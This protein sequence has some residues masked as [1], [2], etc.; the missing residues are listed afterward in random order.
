MKRIRVL[1]GQVQKLSAEKAALQKQMDEFGRFAL[2]FTIESSKF[3]ER[4]NV[5]FSKKLIKMAK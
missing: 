2:P 4:V 3:E 1:E 5:G